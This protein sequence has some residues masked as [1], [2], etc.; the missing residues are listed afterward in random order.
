MFAISKVQ[1]KRISSFRNISITTLVITSSQIKTIFPIQSKPAIILQ[2]DSKMSMSKYVTAIFYTFT[3]GRGVIIDYRN[4]LLWEDEHNWLP[5][6]A[7]VGD[8]RQQKFASVARSNFKMPSPIFWIEL[9]SA[10]GSTY[11]LYTLEITIRDAKLL[12]H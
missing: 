1:E 11:L 3:C 6:F 10:C 2:Y 9:P 12:T 7:Y 8:N 4:L 5:K